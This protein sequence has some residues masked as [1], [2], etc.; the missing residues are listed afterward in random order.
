[1][2]NST[3]KCAFDEQL[4]YNE[5]MRESYTEADVENALRQWA[6]A[7]HKANPGKER[8]LLFLDFDGVIN[9]Y[10][11]DASR[12]MFIGKR[13]Q[14]KFMDVSDEESMK[15]LN[16]LVKKYDPEIIISSSWRYSGLDYCRDYLYHCGLTEWA[17]ITDT[18]ATGEMA[19]RH[20][21]ILY[22][23]EQHHD[24]TNL[25]IL[26]DIYMSELAPHQVMTQFPDG[27][28]KKCLKRAEKLFAQGPIA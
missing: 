16:T 7:Y 27:F 23:L 15:N 24:F 17:K 21:E 19:P 1:M 28:D 18:T 2:K 25:V 8:N 6:S 14:M 11:E 12:E 10:R 3:R 13:S 9:T 4:G 22:W 20:E 26:D 5:V